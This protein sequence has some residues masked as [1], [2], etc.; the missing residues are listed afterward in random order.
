MDDN[1]I[2]FRSYLIERED[3]CKTIARIEQKYMND[4]G[5]QSG[6]IVKVTGKDSAAAFCFPLGED[7]LNKTKLQDVKIEYLNQPSKKTEYPR[8]VLSNLVHCNACPSR[9]MGLVNL[10][11]FSSQNTT[12]KIPEATAVTLGTIDFA[13]KV[14]P[15]YKENLD[16]SPL[17]GRLVGKKD[18]INIPFLSAYS[19]KHQQK[20]SRD[21]PIPPP[22]SFQ[23]VI[24]DAKPENYEFWLI[25]ENTKF[26][27]QNVSMDAFRGVIPRFEVMNLKRV[28]PIVKRLHVEDT[29]IVLA[30]LEIYENSMKINLH[31]QQRIK[32]P[33]D[34]L[35]NPAKVNDISMRM[36]PDSPELVIEIKDDLGNLYADGFSLGGGGSTGPDPETGEIVSN[37]TQDF[38]FAS[39]LDSNAKEITIIVKEIQWIRNHRRFP[40]PTKPPHMTPISPSDVKIT[41]LEGPWEFKI[42]IRNDG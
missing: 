9:R 6:D 20:F 14:M 17:F 5:I 10:E 36:H 41:I 8:I 24:V 29:D 33:D 42:P 21:K 25:T 38:S 13:T 39:T 31:L 4:L 15:D 1:S 22:T 35:S 26:E 2:T 3:K 7:D 28:V 40:K 32:L 37:N 30:S 27:F 23:S 34:F 12:D 11:K 16:Y 18:R 19:Q